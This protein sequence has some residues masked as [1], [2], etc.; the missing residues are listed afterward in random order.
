MHFEI[1]RPEEEEFEHFWHPLGVEPGAFPKLIKTLLLD[2]AYADPNSNQQNLVELG[3]AI[4]AEQP[5]GPPPPWR[6]KVWNNTLGKTFFDALS[7][8]PIPANT[9]PVKLGEIHAARTCL[10]RLDRRMH[11][12]APFS[13]PTYDLS[14]FLNDLL[15]ASDI[16]KQLFNCSQ[17]HL[18]KYL[19]SFKTS[20]E[21]FMTD[22][23]EMKRENSI[24]QAYL[25]LAANSEKIRNM[26][27]QKEV[28][29]FLK[30][31]LGNRLPNEYDNFRKN[32][33]RIGLTK[34]EGAFG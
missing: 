3:Q 28:F 18:I 25:L 9:T 11:E 19:D 12:I 30:E 22:E 14:L 17:D 34:D 15:P 33:K 8:L 21:S 6:L 4:K 23:G 7:P 5:P 27:T 31:R 1:H 26:N 2:A 20:M 32:F 16:E 10:I 29:N 13:S 24:H